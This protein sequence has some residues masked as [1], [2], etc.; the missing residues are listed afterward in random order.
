M[1]TKGEVW[2]LR[3][4][5]TKGEVWSL[6]GVQSLSG[7]DMQCSVEVGNNVGCKDYVGA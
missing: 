2:S 5:V 7:R 4:V 6:R 3:G 1:V